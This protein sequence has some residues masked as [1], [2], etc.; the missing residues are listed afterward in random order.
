MSKFHTLHTH[1]LRQLRHRKLTAAGHLCE[2]CT[3]PMDLE[4]HH[5]IPVHHRPDLALD[6][7]NTVV[8]CRSCH[9]SKHRR[10]VRGRDAW[11]DRLN[12]LTRAV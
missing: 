1:A 11:Q 9:I 8:L 7:D 5:I 12:M 4:V 2:E 6:D 3:S 10:H